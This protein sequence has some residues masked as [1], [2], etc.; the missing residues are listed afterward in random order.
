MFDLDCDGL[1]DFAG[2]T[3]DECA[4]LDAL[5]DSMSRS[6]G[7]SPIALSISNTKLLSYDVQ[8]PKLKLKELLGHI[9]YVYLGEHETLLVI[10]SSKLTPKE[11]EKL[12]EV[13]KE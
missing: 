1:T 10:I 7:P 5:T 13:L 12:I 2:T 9:K 3:L 8:A 6:Y 11:E 4:V